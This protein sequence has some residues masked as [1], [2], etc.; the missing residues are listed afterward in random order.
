MFLKHQLIPILDGEV[1]TQ[2]NFWERPILIQKFTEENTEYAAVTYLLM[3][4]AA[5]WLILNLALALIGMYITTISLPIGVLLLCLI[6]FN[7][8][9]TYRIYVIH[10]SHLSAGTAKGQE[11]EKQKT[12]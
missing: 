7:L 2:N 11:G 10:K 12:Q 9:I 6:I 1:R 3:F 8:I 5:I 4:R